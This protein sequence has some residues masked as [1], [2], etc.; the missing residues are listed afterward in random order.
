MGSFPLD[1]AWPG[2]V[3]SRPFAAP[4]LLA[5]LGAV[6]VAWSH[7]AAAGI[8]GTAVI[9][10]AGPAAATLRRAEHQVDAILRDELTGLS[11]LRCRRRSR[12]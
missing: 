4:V 10:M 3:W 7:S 11:R 5:T 8:A 9:A 12:P 6:L 1:H 2:R